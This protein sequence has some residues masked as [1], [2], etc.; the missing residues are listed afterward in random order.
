MTTATIRLSLDISAHRRVA[1]VPKYFWLCRKHT[2][3]RARSSIFLRAAAR[4]LPFL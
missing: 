3:A 2:C 1:E 4:F